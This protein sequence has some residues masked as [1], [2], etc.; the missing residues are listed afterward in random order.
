MDP[1]PDHG[2]TSYKG[3]G[4]LAGRRAVITRADSGIGRAVA[5]ACAREGADVALNYLLSEEAAQQVV[6][7]IEEAGRK[8][9]A[10]PGDINEE[11]F[12]GTL[13]EQA[14]AAL[15]GIDFLVNVAGKQTAVKEV[16]DLAT[17]QFDATFRTNVYAMFW[18]CKAALPHM[19]PGERRDARP[20]VDA[21]ATGR[22]PTGG[23]NPGLRLH[24]AAEAPRPVGGTSANL[25]PARLAGAS[26]VT[27]EV[28]GVTGGNH[29]P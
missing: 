29:L 28:N 10:L 25:R 20:G 4:R 1:K 9:V 18:L 3:F 13:I 26:F 8:A 17:E 22:R 24:G 6:G 16:A 14:R 15:G 12:C 27:R 2:E 23:E 21:A 7:L 5:I 19:P 11:G